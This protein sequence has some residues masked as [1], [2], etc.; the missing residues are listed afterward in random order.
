MAARPALAFSQPDLS[1]A[2]NHHIANNLALLASLVR[3]QA[4]SIGTRAMQGDEVRSVLE[5]LGG[6][7][8]T[9]ARLHRLLSATG[10]DGMIDLGG[11]LRDV[12]TAAVSA[13]C[14]GGQTE[15]HI[16]CDDR[17]LLPPR[18]VLPLGLIVVELVTNA[19]KYAHPSK[20]PGR[21]AIG[22]R[23]ADA[24]VI[25]QVADDGVGL[26]EGLDPIKDG[27]LGMRLIRLLAA[28]VGAQI[29]FAS[30]EL[31]LSFVLR[32]PS[33]LESLQDGTNRLARVSADLADAGRNH[34][35]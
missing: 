19:V 18:E 11:Y 33:G 20:V 6:Q 23:R 28:Q 25:V 3:M 1:A 31:G 12:S 8:D 21:I 10:F 26:P 15:L 17:C 2:V 30:S 13:L 32:M 7:I 16:D 5:Q 14:P 4:S 27:H 35:R 22:C 9:V 29:S 34:G 24:T